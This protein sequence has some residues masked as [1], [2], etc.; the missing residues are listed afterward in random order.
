L[1]ILTTS[2]ILA[3]VPAA[4]VLGAVEALDVDV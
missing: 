1:P 4:V 3:A 2:T